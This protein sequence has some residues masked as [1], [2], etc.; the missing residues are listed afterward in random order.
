ML[1]IPS[2]LGDEGTPPNAQQP[3]NPCP[4]CPAGQHQ[5]GFLRCDELAPALVPIL[6]GVGVVAGVTLAFLFPKES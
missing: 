3:G 2:M 1:R 4:P 5:T 6:V